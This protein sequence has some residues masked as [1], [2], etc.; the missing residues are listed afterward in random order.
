MH[1]ISASLFS[2]TVHYLINSFRYVSKGQPYSIQVFVT[3]KHFPSF[4]SSNS[5][6]QSAKVNGMH[7]LRKI[8]ILNM[9]SSTKTNCETEQNAF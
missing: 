1:Q 8:Q 6:C 3:G 9:S 4:P 2:N 5:Y 7:R